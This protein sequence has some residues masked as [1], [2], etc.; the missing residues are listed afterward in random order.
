MDPLTIGMTALSAIKMAAPA[1]KDIA[2]VAGDIGKVMDA[3]T[4]LRTPP[5]KKIF[6]D[7]KSIEA[8]ALEKFA[9]KKKAEKLELDMKNYIISI[10]G[11]NG[12]N[13]VLRIQGSI[14]KERRQQEADAYERRRKRFELF[15]SILV[16]VSFGVAFFI[17]LFFIYKVVSH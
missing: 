4:A 1:R 14:R 11:P 17:M 13:Q 16:I 12:W 15:I 7:A 8:E 2:S 6:A 10:Y 3:C 9:N 5:K